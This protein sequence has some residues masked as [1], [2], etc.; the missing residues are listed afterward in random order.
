MKILGRT[1]SG[2]IGASIAPAAVVVLASL[3]QLPLWAIALLGG[4][5]AVGSAVMSWT[6]SRRIAR[7]VESTIDGALAIARGEFGTQVQLSGKD[8]LGDLA[9][10]FNFMSGQLA[11]YDADKKELIT[12]LE[13]G[14]MQTIVALANSIDSKDRYTRGHSQR[15]GDLAQDIGKE[16]GVEGTDLRDLR[17]GGILHDIGK[18]GAPEAILTKRD[19]L[20]DEEMAIMRKHPEAGCADRRAYGVHGRHPSGSEEPP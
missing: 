7:T 11:Q 19:K 3:L 18:I 8:E 14:Y 9:H 15:V 5:T 20:T 10:T 16:L 2:L 13:Q 12:R 6:V 4:A 1:T 17:Y